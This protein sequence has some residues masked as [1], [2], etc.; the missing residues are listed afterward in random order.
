MWRVFILGFRWGKNRYCLPHPA[1]H[2]AP[3]FSH[4][5][6][7]LFT[8]TAEMKSH[9]SSIC[10]MTTLQR[11]A[12]NLKSIE[13]NELKRSM[14]ETICIKAKFLLKASH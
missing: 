2:L 3:V 8:H 5:F 9:I 12:L 10:Q 14:A 11:Q 7:W 4:I 1:L 13:A 6:S